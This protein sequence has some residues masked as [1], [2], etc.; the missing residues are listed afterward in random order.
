MTIFNIVIALD[1]WGNLVI[2]VSGSYIS[3]R[4]VKACLRDVY[5]TAMKTRK[6]TTSTMTMYFKDID[7]TLCLLIY[8]PTHLPIYLSTYPTYPAQS[9][10]CLSTKSLSSVLLR[11]WRLIKN[12]NRCEDQPNA[13]TRC[14]ST[15]DVSDDICIHYVLRWERVKL[16]SLRIL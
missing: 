7:C 12:V 14:K 2:K 4:T 6:Y 10:L 13:S 9:R 16:P 3:W 11:V 5:R 8:L 15:R 1:V